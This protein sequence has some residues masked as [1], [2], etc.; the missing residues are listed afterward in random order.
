MDKG[1]RTIHYKVFLCKQHIYDQGEVVS[2]QN[3][4]K[5]KIIKEEEVF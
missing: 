1:G 3:F 2:K 5:Q 4:K